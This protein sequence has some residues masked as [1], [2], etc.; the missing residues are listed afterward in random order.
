MS[1]K[2][3]TGIPVPN[4]RGGEGGVQKYPFRQMKAGD[5][6]FVE[7]KVKDLMSS[8][9][10]CI[11]NVQKGKNPCKSKFTTRRWPSDAPTGVRVFCITDGTEVAPGLRAVS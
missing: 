4:R 7:G 1:I 6:F 3:E 2:I 9:S 11:F 8:L 10:S 5:S